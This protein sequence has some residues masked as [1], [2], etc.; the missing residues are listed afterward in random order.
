M[1]VALVALD[2]QADSPVQVSNETRTGVWLESFTAAT[3]LA[4]SLKAPLVLFWA[5]SSCGECEKLETAVNLESFRTWQTKHSDYVYC[6]VQGTS[7]ADIE[8]NEGTGACDFARSAG[9]TK[10]V[11]NWLTSFPFICVW[12]PKNGVETLAESFV[13]RSGRM[14]VPRDP[15]MSL[16]ALAEHDPEMLE[17]LAIELEQSIQKLCGSYTTN[18]TVAGFQCSDGEGDRLEIESNTSFVDIPLKRLPGVA[19]DNLLVA[20]WP[21]N[22][23]PPVT[24]AIHWAMGQTNAI[25]SL[26]L[27]KFL[28]CEFPTGKSIEL[29]LIDSKGDVVSSSFV[30]CVDAQVNSPTNPYFVGESTIEELRY[31][32]WTLDY[33]LACRKVVEGKAKAILAI[34]SGVLWC[35]YCK[36][37]E[38]SLFASDLFRDW[39]E[40]NRVQLVLFDQA[41]S[42]SDTYADAGHLLSYAAGLE[43]IHTGNE[44]K[45]VSGAAYLSR[46]GLH[47]DDPLVLAAHERSVRNSV[48]EWKAPETSATRLSTPTL[49]LID[50]K[51]RVVGRCSTWRDR[52]GE[53]GSD[54][55]YYDPE[56]NIARLDDLLKLAN[57]ADESSDYVSTTR[58]ELSVAGGRA[59]VD[60]QICDAAEAFILRGFS[61]GSFS[62]SVSSTHDV[63]ISLVLDGVVVAC[64]TN[65]LEFAVRKSHA[66]SLR[67]VLK[68][69]GTM[70]ARVA[71]GSSCYAAE[72]SCEFVPG[73]GN[74]EASA[75]VGFQTKCILETVEVDG[76]SR[77]TVKKK[78]GQLPNGL[79]LYVDEQTG[80]VCLRGQAKKKGI[81]DFSYEVTR[82]IGNAN[83]PSG[84]VAV[85]V[86]IMDPREFNQFVGVGGLWTVPLVKA[87]GDGT[88]DVV[89]MVTLKQSKSGKLSAKVVELSSQ[90][91]FFSGY[92]SYMNTD[93]GEASAQLI[94]PKHSLKL[95]LSASG[96]LSVE[97]GGASGSSAMGE[98]RSFAGYYTMAFGVENV[99]GGNFTGSG[100]AMISVSKTG[101]VRLKGSLPS[102]TRF[103]A[104]SMLAIDPEDSEYA[105]LPI[106]HAE[107]RD[108]LS[109][110]LRIH[111]NGE[112]YYADETTARVV[113]PVRG[114]AARWRHVGEFDAFTSDLDCYGIYYAKRT[115]LES[116]LGLF[117]LKS[118]VC[119]IMGQEVPDAICRINSSS[120]LVSGK[121]TFNFGEEE[122]KGNFSGVLTPGWID[123]G[124]IAESFP[125]EFAERPF[126]S[127]Y[128]SYK[129]EVNGK[130]MT[131]TVPFNMFAK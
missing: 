9:F 100:Y 70:P 128:F 54:V 74:E 57:R 126:A 97:F 8:V 113:R 123:C 22:V 121:A 96:V 25:V 26:S 18:R 43:H 53:I 109:A 99:S 42:E 29:S 71:G 16:S 67:P 72:V 77:V 44:R 76:C 95:I 41:F 89:G 83:I 35:P 32:D 39:L 119:S 7:G 125:G 111:A 2:A 6:Y 106:L 36:G 61:T 52:N 17:L 10:S 78:S 112:K 87:S 92:W 114:V 15:A 102:G 11:G 107:R 21:G 127:G 69:T 115:T 1:T 103:S 91:K 131:S 59:Q 13:G 56:E 68:L 47:A 34:Y 64:G 63:M 23:L 122:V 4:Q 130:R 38:Q 105:I 45:M 60:F 48:S 12:W 50:G 46:H 117:D 84:V 120:G 65:S 85:T 49:L 58:R 101:T 118:V 90:A 110:L 55:R 86:T 40:D 81:F 94:S 116:W 20:A 19:D 88:S 82:K 24:N 104:K 14:L 66:Q 3:N 108:S 124:C 28:G 51:G 93:S 37:M 129:T 62:V 31:S 30:H 5:N 27:E 98:L 80:A 33:D 75:Y 79:R 73:S